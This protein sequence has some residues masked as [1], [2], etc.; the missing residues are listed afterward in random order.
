M[1]SLH[2]LSLIILMYTGA[3]YAQQDIL[4]T[5]YLVF[6]RKEPASL[7]TVFSAL[8]NE[9]VFLNPA[10]VATI[11]DNRITLGGSVSDLGNSYILAWS[12]PNLSIASASHI[13]SLSDSTYNEYRKELLKFS[14]AISNQDMGLYI[15]NTVMTFG[16]AVKRISD[17]LY[18]DAAAEFGGDAVSFDLGLNIYWQSIAFEIAM[19][20]I[21][22]PKIG[23]SD[24]SYGQSTSFTTRYMSP[25]GF[26]IAVQGINSTTYAGSDVGINLAAQQAFLD[27]RLTSR[28]QLTSFFSGS[29]AI[30]QNISGSVGYRPLVPEDMY[31]LQDLEISYTLSFLAL[32]QNVGTH[33][34]VLTK[35]F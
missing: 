4:Y 26:T 29:E 9:P 34:V 12:T 28:I 18:A 5:D 14:M 20:N 32:P 21:N 10:S 22:S 24:I 3:V 8:A 33:L 6:G 27:Q 1:K 13:A 11:T 17:R 31:F 15:K 30:M 35:Y 2:A 16:V 23:S 25:S 19:L 7:G